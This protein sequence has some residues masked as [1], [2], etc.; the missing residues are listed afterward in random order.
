MSQI[1]QKARFHCRKETWEYS[2]AVNFVHLVS[3][4]LH[5]SFPRFYPQTLV[6]LNLLYVYIF[7]IL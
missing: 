1:N 2:E 6:S 3:P 7:Y 4:D 5:D